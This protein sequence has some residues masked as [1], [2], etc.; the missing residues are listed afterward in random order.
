MRGYLLE[1]L[2][3]RMPYTNPT[4]ISNSGNKYFTNQKSKILKLNLDILDNSSILQNYLSAKI[5]EQVNV[6]SNTN[7]VT[8][9]RSVLAQQKNTSRT[10]KLNQ[11]NEFEQSTQEPF[12][13]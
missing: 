1:N 4:A 13:L 5:S 10:N 7:T 3:N 12:Q 8:D 6:S 11:S 9:F 2:P